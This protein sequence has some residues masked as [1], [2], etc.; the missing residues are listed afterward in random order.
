MWPPGRHQ[1]VSCVSILLAGDGR[2][3]S[4]KPSRSRG[5]S[6]LPLGLLRVLLTRG[7]EVVG[8]RGG[9]EAASSLWS[10]GTR[11]SVH[12]L[13][14]VDTG[15]R[16]PDVDDSRPGDSARSPESCDL[17]GCSSEGGILRR[18]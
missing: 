8:I 6:N 18:E 16:C 12:I 1:L 15:F 3:P 13:P 7:I 9:I 11:S 4:T 10:L 2:E 5:T 14:R 17:S